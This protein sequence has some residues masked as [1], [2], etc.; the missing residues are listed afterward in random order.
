MKCSYCNKGK[1]NIKIIMEDEKKYLKETC[2]NC[3]YKDKIYLHKEIEN[4][5]I[6]TK[7]N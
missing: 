6:K 5:V 2:N 1:I 7:V 4:E 3:G